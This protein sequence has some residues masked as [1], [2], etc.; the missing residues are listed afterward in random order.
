MIHLK[1]GAKGVNFKQMLKIFEPEGEIF[2]IDQHVLPS[3]AVDCLGWRPG[4]YG[5]LQEIVLFNQ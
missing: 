2:A 5:V 3:R 1:N 4:Q